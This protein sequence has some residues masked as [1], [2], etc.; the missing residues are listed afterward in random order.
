MNCAIPAIRQNFDQNLLGRPSYWSVVPSTSGWI[1]QNLSSDLTATLGFKFSNSIRFLNEPYINKLRAFKTTM[2]QR[3]KNMFGRKSKE[4][5]ILRGRINDLEHRRLN[6]DRRI[7]Q[8]Y[9]KINALEVV[10]NQLGSFKIVHSCYKDN[11]IEEGYK[12]LDI[13]GEE[14]SFA[15]LVKK[16]NK[17]GS[18]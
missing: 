5:E 13:V 7:T 14:Y 10:L 2:K 12:L 3:M 17:K 8:S 4:L 6:D 9:N 18:K 15:V 1:G 16:N 11:M